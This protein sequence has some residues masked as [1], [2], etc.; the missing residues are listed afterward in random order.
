[1][2]STHAAGV[3]GGALLVP[4]EKSTDTTDRESFRPGLSSTAAPAPAPAPAAAGSAVAFSAD[5]GDDDD[6]EDDDDSV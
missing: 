3:T 4:Q 2:C 1:M 6:D 5:D